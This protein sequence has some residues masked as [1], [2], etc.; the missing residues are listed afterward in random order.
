[1]TSMLSSIQNGD[2]AMKVGNAP[3]SLEFQHIFRGNTLENK[4]VTC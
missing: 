2:L 4:Y 3:I 1:M